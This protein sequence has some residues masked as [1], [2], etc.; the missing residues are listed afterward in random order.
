[1]TAGAHSYDRL[2]RYASIEFICWGNK[3]YKSEKTTDAK[4]NEAQPATSK[5]ARMPYRSPV[6]RELGD[7][8]GVTLGGSPG[9]GES[10]FTTVFKP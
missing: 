3:M 7:V 5:Q 9:A 1:M 6:L 4:S 10:G 8:R 2:G